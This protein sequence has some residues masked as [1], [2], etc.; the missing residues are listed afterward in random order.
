MVKNLGLSMHG[1]GCCCGPG[2][3][4]GPGI[5]GVAEKKR[6]EK[7]KENRNTKSYKNKE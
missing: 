6:K 2:L 5:L 4:N 7:W 3:I 1:S